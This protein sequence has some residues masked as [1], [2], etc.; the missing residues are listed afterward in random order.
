MTINLAKFSAYV[1]FLAVSFVG[2]ERL[3]VMPWSGSYI[4]LYYLFSLPFIWLAWKGRIG[5]VNI[6]YGSVGMLLVTSIM[7][8]GFSEVYL[9]KKALLL[10]YILVASLSLAAYLYQNKLNGILGNSLKVYVL[11]NILIVLGQM[12]NFYDGKVLAGQV[13]SQR[14]LNL[15]AVI[16][17][18][19][20]RP[21]GYSF[22]SNKGMFNFSY[23]LIFLS[24][25]SREGWKWMQVMY[26]LTFIA[27]SRSTI[28]S[29]LTALSA[30]SKFYAIFSVL[31]YLLVLVFLTP[32]HV[33]SDRLRDI[34]STSSNFVRLEL[35]KIW[36]G[37]IESSSAAQI[38]LGHGIGSSGIY[39]ART[40]GTAYGD[41][42]N[43]YLTIIYELGLSGLVLIGMVFVLLWRTYNKEAKYMLLMPL[44]IFQLFYSNLGEPLVII[45]LGYFF[46]KFKNERIC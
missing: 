34:H 46:F 28:L 14:I 18:D 21:S 23:A 9:W 15:D 8:N 6:V 3:N 13:D 16:I 22:D 35:I 40:L 5:G 17:S 38:L 32:E 12:F 31:L 44:L 10:F 1:A 45:T 30:R 29:V 19:Y 42:A 25:I 24:L 20:F 43:G 33:F 7:L 4:Q 39:L 36:I 26:P 2:F 27:H 41:F 37:G 11:V